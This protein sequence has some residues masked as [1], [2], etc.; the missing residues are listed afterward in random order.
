MIYLLLSITSHAATFQ[1]EL[2]CVEPAPTLRSPNTEITHYAQWS[3]AGTGH[4][5]TVVSSSWPYVECANR[6]GVIS[7]TFRA[8]VSNW[9]TSFPSTVSCTHNNDQLVLTLT[10]AL[11]SS[12]Y[13]D[14][15]D[16][17]DGVM[18]TL[19]ASLSGPI[20]HLYTGSAQLE[21]VGFTKQWLDQGW[22]GVK[23][24]TLSGMPW[25]GISCQVGRPQGNAP[26]PVRIWTSEA[27]RFGSGYCV[28]PVVGGGTTSVPV[29]INSL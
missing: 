11:L 6:N 12:N 10:P 9:P 3:G 20:E 27:A 14:T 22:V 15:I 16:E 21:T 29:T 26:T 13:D 7:A 1:Q 2:P 8:T 19:P 25:T 23:A 24:T 18:L 4:P 17:L 28:L 5:D